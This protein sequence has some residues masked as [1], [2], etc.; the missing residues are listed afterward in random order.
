M[1]KV[2]Q[3]ELKEIKNLLDHLDLRFILPLK[4][5]EKLEKF[6]RENIS[7]LKRLLGETNE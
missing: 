6:S 2:L 4:E 3:P 7:K 5:L 1:P